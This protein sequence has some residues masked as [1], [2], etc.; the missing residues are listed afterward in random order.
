MLMAMDELERA[1]LDSRVNP[2]CSSRIFLHM[3]PELGMMPQDV[4]TEWKK[5]MDTMISRHATRL[6]K[7]RVDEIEVKAR[8]SPEGSSE[9]SRTRKKKKNGNYRILARGE[10]IKETAGILPWARFRAAPSTVLLFSSVP[11]SRSV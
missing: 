9:V 10:L 1:M 3:M 4:V 7:L 11:A 6:L 8:I 5:V 2:A